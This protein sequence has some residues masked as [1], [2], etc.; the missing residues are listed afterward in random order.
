MLLQT[1]SYFVPKDKR[2]EHARLMHRFRALM[3]RLGCDQFDVCEQSGPDW[4][5]ERGGRFVQ[6]MKFRDSAHQKSVRDAE[7]SDVGAQDL[8]REFCELVDYA[9]QQQQGMATTA[10]YRG[11]FSNPTS[12]S[13][14]RSSVPELSEDSP[15][16]PSADQLDE[17]P[18]I[19]SPRGGKKHV[20]RNGEIDD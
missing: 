9:L 7:Q 3:A 1:N 6:L 5:S 8:V 19:D 16:L 13:A 20:A 4:N 2:T 15:L 11:I 12:A 14:T 10:F 18:P 17:I